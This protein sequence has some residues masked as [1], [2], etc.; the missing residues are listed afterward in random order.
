MSPIDS[1]NA[2][3][4]SAG[5]ELPGIAT[6]S[7]LDETTWEFSFDDDSALVAEWIPDPSRL[8]LTF[9]LGH[10]MESQKLTT[11]EVLL[12]YNLLW[13][14]TNGA[15][16][17]LGGP[18]GEAHLIYEFHADPPLE[19][20]FRHV[21]TNLGRMAA[22]WRQFIANGVSDRHQEALT[23]DASLLLA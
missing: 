3:I 14:D 17:G 5:P 13:Q 8:V 10:I 15:R 4:R 18:Q 2:L 9:P 7:R 22:A 16:I 19:E 12:S 11:Y 23:E 6:F 21:V 1:V 20:A